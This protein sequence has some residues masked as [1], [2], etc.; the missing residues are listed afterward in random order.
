MRFAS[1]ALQTLQI[2]AFSAAFADPR[3]FAGPRSDGADLDHIR[4]IISPHIE[5][6]RLI[7]E[8]RINSHIYDYIQYEAARVAA[9]RV[10]DLNSLGGNAE[11]ALM[12]ARKVKELGK[13]TE[14]RSQ[15][16]CAS[17]CVAIFAA[18]RERMAA[19]DTWI[20]I[21]GARL[22]PGYTT[23]FEGFCF[24]DLEGG[25]AFEPRKRGCREFLNHWYDVTLAS[26]NEAFDLMESNGVSPELRETYFSMPDDP[27]W[28][29]QMNAIRKPDWPLKA[30]DAVKYNLVT[31]LLAKTNF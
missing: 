9:V 12:I 28:P 5:G 6:D 29:A 21:H 3:D 31:K 15:H 20:G 22:G 27:G 7:I 11:W 19:E 26:T 16:Y 1:I 25:M 10:I 23:N 30:A 18:G 17:A 4:R 24:E 8:G 2:L 14:L 13:T